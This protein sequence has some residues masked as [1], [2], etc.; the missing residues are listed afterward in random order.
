[1]MVLVI[2]LKRNTMSTVIAIELDIPDDLSR[3]RL[4]PGVNSRLQELLD[5]QDEG[6]PLSA[7]GKQEAEGLVELSE[8]LSLIKLRAERA[9][10]QAHERR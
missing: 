6:K 1:M 8:L 5:R 10:H 9:G 4:S 3:F 7:A 2:C